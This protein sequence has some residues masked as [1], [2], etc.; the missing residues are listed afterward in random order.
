MQYDK[1][2][3]RKAFLAQFKKEDMFANNFDELD[4][5]SR[6]VME[7]VEEYLAATKKDYLSWGS[8]E[9]LYN[10]TKKKLTIYCLIFLIFCIILGSW[11][12]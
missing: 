12:S 10:S 6:V 5:S 4:N 2:R 3:K 1:L 8:E 9:V 7:L 11:M